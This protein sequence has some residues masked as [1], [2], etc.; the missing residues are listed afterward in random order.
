MCIWIFFYLHDPS[1]Q[2]Q[3]LPLVVIWQYE[4]YHIWQHMWVE[5]NYSDENVIIMENTISDIIINITLCNI[6]YIL[7][8]KN[9]IITYNIKSYKKWLTV[10]HTTWP[11]ASIEAPAS[12]SNLITSAWPFLAAYISAVLLCWWKYY[13]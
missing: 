12:S 3:R 6:H 5:S 10:I 1:L 2:Y 4:L 13:N 7:M 11:F 9:H 8:H